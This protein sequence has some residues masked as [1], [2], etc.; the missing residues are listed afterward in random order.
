[1]V[2][3]GGRYQRRNHL[4]TGS[5]A[6]WRHQT[7]CNPSE[8]ALQLHKKGIRWTAPVRGAVRFFQFVRKSSPEELTLLKCSCHKYSGRCNWRRDDFY[9]IIVMISS[10]LQTRNCRR[11][12]A[13]LFRAHKHVFINCALLHAVR[14][15]SEQRNLLHKRGKSYDIE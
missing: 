6:L 12:L 7:F 11:I 10:L 15:F 2:R 9:F 3:R 13:A 8:S 14:T 4:N 1:M 5:A